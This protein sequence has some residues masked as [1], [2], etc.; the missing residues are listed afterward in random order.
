MPK[1]QNTL[2]VGNG[3]PAGVILNPGPFAALDICMAQGIM[4]PAMPSGVLF[5]RARGTTSTTLQCAYHF[6]YL[7]RQQY[8]C[9]ANTSITVAAI[10]V[11]LKLHSVH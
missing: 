3:P 9:V 11:W 5:S 1:N 10:C 6:W 7:L 8:E 4:G 2:P